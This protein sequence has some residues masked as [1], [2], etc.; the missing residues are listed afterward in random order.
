MRTKPLLLIAL[1]TLATLAKAEIGDTFTFNGLNYNVLSESPKTC[2]VGDNTTFAEEALI[3]PNEANGYQVVAISENAFKQC[4]NLKTVEIPANVTTIDVYSFYQCNALTMFTVDVS[5]TAYS[6]LGGVLFDKN[7]TKLVQYPAARTETNYTIPE[8]VTTIGR[9]AFSDCSILKSIT[10]PESVTTF[11]GAAFYGSTSLANINIPQS[12]T[13]IGEGAFAFS[14]I[15]AIA[16][17]SSITTLEK[18]TFSLCPSLKTVFI[19]SSVTSIGSM[20]FFACN[21]ME[22]F[23][24][25]IATPL[26]LEVDAFLAVDLSTVALEIPIGS[27][28]AYMAAPIWKDFKKPFAEVDFSTSLPQTLQEQGIRVWGGKG[29]LNIETLHPISI[30]NIQVYNMAGQLIHTV[31]IQNAVSARQIPLPEGIYLVSVENGAEKVVVR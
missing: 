5:N 30:K 10:T 9:F 23:S 18:M 26:P 24:V 14:G 16:I 7:Q 21:G 22:T 13:S 1:I 12:V 27:T 29:V 31:N 11:D 15:E 20:C 4:G 3:I 19:P 8:G 28:D 2:E 17:P 6:H 25:N